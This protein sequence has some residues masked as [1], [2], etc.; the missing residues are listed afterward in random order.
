MRQCNGVRLA[1]DQF[2]DKD[3]YKTIQALKFDSVGDFNYMVYT[4]RAMKN[5]SA[6]SNHRD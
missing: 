5:I 6:P 3:N 1:S 2:V 4:R